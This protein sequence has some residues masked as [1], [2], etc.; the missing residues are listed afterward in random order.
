MKKTRVRKPSIVNIVA[1]ADLRQ[2][3]DLSKVSYIR[4]I[5]FDPE[6]YGGRV[7][8]LKTP[9]M[10]G[11]V[12]IFP[13]GKLISIGT[14]SR[15]KAEED[16]QTT[17]DI[18]SRHGLINPTRITAKIRN[19]V[20][21]LTL[22]EPLRLEEIVSKYSAIYEPEQFPAVIMK[23]AFPKATLLIFSS[24]KI[25]IVGVKDLNELKQV[26]DRIQKII[27]KEKPT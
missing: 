19:I 13:S 15:T 16:L 24:G 26:S 9:P 22:S 7:A 4:H 14:K 20:A 23:M 1:T 6:V 3:I 11:K 8:Y 27:K 21:V 12:S 25:V 10:H 18:L 2:Q 5:I 17:A